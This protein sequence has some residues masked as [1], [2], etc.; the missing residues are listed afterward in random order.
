MSFEPWPDQYL[1]VEECASGQKYIVPISDET[2]LDL[3]SLIDS[4]ISNQYGGEF[5]RDGAI[6]PKLAGDYY[7]TIITD[8]RPPDSV[9]VWQSGG[10]YLI[11]PED[12]LTDSELDATKA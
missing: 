1:F 8:G 2:P 4:W 5:M 10:F 6:M 9:V 7:A 11:R 12:K 3:E